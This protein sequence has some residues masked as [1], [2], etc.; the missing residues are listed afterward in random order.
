MSYVERSMGKQERLILR[1]RFHWWYDA[2]AW[3]ALV[4]LGVFLIGIWIWASMMLQK[5][6]TEVAV[7][8]HRFVLK[9]GLIG[10]HT[11]EIAIQNIEGVQFTQTLI[12]RILGFGR[13]RVE[14]TGEDAVWTP[15]L[16]DPIAIRAALE[17]ARDESASAPV[18]RPAS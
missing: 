17:T 14:G 9:R 12:G 7:T 13:I 11:Y 15:E 3:A 1:A 16:A 8:S 18:T 5:W 4:F 2:T 10:V 6:N